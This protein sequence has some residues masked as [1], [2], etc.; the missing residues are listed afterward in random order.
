[1]EHSIILSSAYFGPVQYFAKLTQNHK[2]YIE[3]YDHYQKQTYRNRCL[4]LTGNG[5]IALTIPVVRIN[6]NKTLVKDIRIFN[7]EAWQK[8]HLRALKAAY[9]NSPF[10]E[11]YIDALL[12]IWEKKWDFL[13]DLNSYSIQCLA[14][15]LETQFSVQLTNSFMHSNQTS[16]DFRDKI[17]PKINKE[18]KDENFT[19]IPY[20]QVFLDRFSFQPNLSILDLLFNKGPETLSYLKNC[21][22]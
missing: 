7:Q 14:E 11:F 20:H 18:V 13:V 8:N 17:H 22:T 15:E 21:T 5:P 2:T 12:P 4:I 6:G 3:Q 9:Q 1:M 19:P 10:Y 16:Y